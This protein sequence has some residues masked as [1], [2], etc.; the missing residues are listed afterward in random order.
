MKQIVSIFL[1]VLVTFSTSAIAGSTKVQ[2]KV[3]EVWLFSKNY[4]TYNVND[5]GLANIYL[6]GSV[7][8]PACGTGARR[9][10]ISTDHP[11]YQSVV[12]MALMAK[13]TGKTVEIW[14]LDTCTQRSSS[15][16]F[17]LMRL[18]D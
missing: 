3:S 1:T 7:I 5:V 13:Q 9:V 15:W 14:H 2:G 6:E 17:G 16:D 10:V 11:L 18:L 12:S 8:E 4:S